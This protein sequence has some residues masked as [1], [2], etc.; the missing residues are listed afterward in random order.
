MTTREAPA[1]VRTITVLCGEEM[2]RA[3]APLKHSKTLRDRHG[4]TYVAAEY[5]EAALLAITEDDLR[6]DELFGAWWREMGACNTRIE[7][8]VEAI[9]EQ[10]VLAY[11][12]DTYG[13]SAER[14]VA[15]ALNDMAADAGMSRIEL[16]DWLVDN[17]S[18]DAAYAR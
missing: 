9:K 13:I 3:L 11:L 5:D 18:A 12:C 7:F 8:D 4:C 2:L 14:N 15:V 10:G 1:Q 6:T 16:L 17:A